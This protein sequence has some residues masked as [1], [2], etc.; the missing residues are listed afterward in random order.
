[1]FQL[2]CGTYTHTDTLLH[3]ASLVAMQY[4]YIYSMHTEKSTG[5]QSIVQGY[6]F[7]GCCFSFRTVAVK[8]DFLIKILPKK[9]I[10]Q[11]RVE[12]HTSKV[13]FWIERDREGKTLPY[14]RFWIRRTFTSLFL[15]LSFFLID[16]FS[17]RQWQQPNW[18]QN[19]W[20]DS[21][22]TNWFLIANLNRS[23]IKMKSEWMAATTAQRQRQ[24]TNVNR[25]DKQCQNIN[26]LHLNQCFNVLYIFL[27]FVSAPFLKI[28]T[29]KMILWWNITCKSNYFI[30]Q[31]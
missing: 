31:F 4:S 2:K 29:R 25:I 9:I 7:S 30:L 13:I 20:N 10:P 16:L 3:I 23:V 28:Q 24:R 5:K 26:S 27:Y 21:F 12:I 1:M 8:R 17:H 18:W 15:S 11:E 6:L 22:P 14:L 19:E